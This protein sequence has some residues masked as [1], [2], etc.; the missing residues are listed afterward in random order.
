VDFGILLDAIISWFTSLDQKSE[1]IPL[2]ADFGRMLGVL[3]PEA[4]PLT[5][6]LITKTNSPWAACFSNGLFGDVTSL[7]G[8]MAETLECEGVEITAIPVRRR[9]NQY[10]GY[11]PA[12]QFTLYSGKVVNHSN[13]RR[14]IV[15]MNDGGKWIF[16]EYGEMQR[17]EIPE[18][19]ASNRIRDRFTVDMLEQYCRALGIDPFDPSFYGTSGV[20]LDITGAAPGSRLE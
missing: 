2:H 14:S 20:L 4:V 12:S 1:I 16:E 15:C 3:G 17:F 6:Y 9:S 5:K 8:Y 19:Y 13:V 18:R 11:Y 10:E 7:I